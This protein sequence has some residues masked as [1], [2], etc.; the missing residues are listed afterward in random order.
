TWPAR[1]GAGAMRALAWVGLG[2]GLRALAADERAGLAGDSR[3]VPEYAPVSD[4]RDAVRDC[5]RNSAGDGSG[6]RKERSAGFRFHDD[7]AR[8]SVYADILVGYGPQPF[9]RRPA[10]LG[11][12]PRRHR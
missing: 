2:R 11:S 7:R 1:P 4:R 5:A 6:G 10:A 8:R 3:P 12:G 9:I